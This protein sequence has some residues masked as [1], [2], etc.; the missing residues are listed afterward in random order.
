MMF[1]LTPIT[2]CDNRLCVEN[3]LK[4][5]HKNKT[6]PKTKYPPH[7]RNNFIG[8]GQLHKVLL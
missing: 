1:R 4:R 6:H 7:G 2:R 5:K 3:F 8:T